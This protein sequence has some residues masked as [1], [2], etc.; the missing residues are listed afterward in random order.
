[1][2]ACIVC[3]MPNAHGPMHTNLAE[4]EMAPPMTRASH[5]C[6][7]STTGLCGA[8]FRPHW[9]YRTQRVI[10]CKAQPAQRHRQKCCTSG[11]L[12]LAS[13]RAIARPCCC[14][15]RP[16]PGLLCPLL[17]TSPST[18]SSLLPVPALSS[19]SL[20]CFFP[21]CLARFRPVCARCFHPPA[22]SHRRAGMLGE[23]LERTPS[24][25]AC[26]RE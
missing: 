24:S 7:G 12:A 4:R 1:M 21:P 3:I 9:K 22:A 18:R 6:P 20:A 11:P 15:G 19:P 10:L 8:V 16:S 25:G 2:A 17:A 14:L 23:S 5:S 26:V 13:L